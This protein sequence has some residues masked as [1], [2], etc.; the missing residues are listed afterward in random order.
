MKLSIALSDGSEIPR[1]GQGTW[2]MG[3]RGSREEAEINSLRLGIELGMTLI[4]TAEMY[5]S[6][7]AESVVGKAIKPYDRESLYIVSK[8]Y[9]HNAG[10]RHI[11]QSCDDSAK[12]LGTDYLDMYLLH[13]QGS[14]PLEETAEC[15]EELVAR[16][17]IR[18]WGVSNFDIDDMKSLFQIPN[19]DK[20][21]TNQVLYHLG[22]R[23][24]EYALLPWMR[25][26][27]MPF[28]AYC[29][30]AQGGALRHQLISN[31]VVKQISK[32]KQ[33]SSMQ[34]LLAFALSQPDSIV[35]PKSSNAL[36]VKQNAEAPLIELSQREL[37]LL[38]GEFPTPTA[39][40]HL[41]IQ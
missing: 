20:C 11:F 34:L 6:G 12:R 32:E 13:W 26:H 31:P 40:T 33:C 17:K 1:L 16:G 10:R 38:D 41:D 27:R 4:D 9:P 25:N 23:G 39:K 28:M 18:R 35:I 24:I 19:G 14:V 7:G 22:S 8:V 30:L 15:M 21:V 2:H 3:E 37:D 5:G 36:H 29:P